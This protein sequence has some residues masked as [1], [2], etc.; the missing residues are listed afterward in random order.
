VEF[1]TLVNMLMLPFSAL[2]LVGAMNKYND[3]SRKC[4][5]VRKLCHRVLLIKGKR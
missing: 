5:E 3:A 4:D 2:L 1:V